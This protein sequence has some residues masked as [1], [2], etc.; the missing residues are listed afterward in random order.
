MRL[1][2]ELGDSSITE[3]ESERGEQGDEDR[4]SQ[5]EGGALLGLGRWERVGPQ[6][7]GLKEQSSDQKGTEQ[8]FL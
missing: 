1:K 2:V 3:R 5:E 6:G 4:R 8:C 7:R